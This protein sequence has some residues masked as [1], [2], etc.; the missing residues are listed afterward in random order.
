[1]SAK[2]SI[3]ELLADLDERIA[4]HGEQ[5]ALHTEREAFHREQRAVHAAELE[6]L[7]RYAETLRGATEAAAELEG[8]APIHPPQPPP[9]PAPAPAPVVDLYGPGGRFYLVPAI[10]ALVARK[11][12]GEAFAVS[13]MTA[14]VNRVYSGQLREKVDERQVSVSLRWLARQGRIVVLQRG[15]GRRAARYARAR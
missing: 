14:E 7:R 2:Q 13:S 8:A 12:P 11:A 6:K 15:R 10:Q 4:H 1:M 5:E 3:T 9:A